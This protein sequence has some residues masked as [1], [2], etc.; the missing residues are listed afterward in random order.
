[1]SSECTITSPSH[2]IFGPGG[3]VVDCCFA[4]KFARVSAGLLPFWG[5]M[6]LL[7]NFGKL[8]RGG[9]KSTRNLGGLSDA[10]EVRWATTSSTDHP[11]HRDCVLQASLGTSARSSA[12]AP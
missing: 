7:G 2:V 4:R 12:R 5:A 9:A 6:P 8:K 11:S 10:A 1:M 3:E